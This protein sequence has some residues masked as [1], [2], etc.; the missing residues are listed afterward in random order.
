MPGKAIK[1]PL[2]MPDSPKDTIPH[3]RPVGKTGCCVDHLSQVLSGESEKGRSSPVARQDRPLALRTAT[4]DE[5]RPLGLEGQ[6]MSQRNLDS[7]SEL[8]L[9][10]VGEICLQDCQR[11]FPK[12]VAQQTVEG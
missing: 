7:R 5:D 10:V 11:I 8:P 2:C 9:P 6:E 1:K 4:L 3:D 12:W